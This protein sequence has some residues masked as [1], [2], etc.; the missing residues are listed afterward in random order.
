MT[1]VA[2]RAV[3]VL[4][5]LL[6][7]GAPAG[8]AQST[9]TAAGGLLPDAIANPY[10]LNDTADPEDPTL[11]GGVLTLSTSEDAEIMDYLQ[12]DAQ[13][14]PPDPWVIEIEM[15]HVSGS[16]SVATRA[17]VQ[18]FV[19][20]SPNVGMLFQIGADSLFLMADAVTIGQSATVDT[21]DTFHTY[22]LEVH[23]GG[24]FDVYYDTVLTLQGT[25]YTS[26]SNHGS[27][28]RVGFGP[29]STG[30]HGVS[31]WVSFSHDG[32]AT[33]TTTTFS[34]TTTSST[35]T[36]TT[37]PAPCAP[38]PSGL[39]SWWPGEGDAADIAGTNT[40]SVSGVTF[41]AGRVNQ[42]FEFDGIS[43]T[44]IEVAESSDLKFVGSFSIDAWVQTTG[45]GISG[46]AADLFADVVRKRHRDDGGN[47]DIFL[48]M[49]N[50]VARFGVV[51]DAGSFD[52]PMGI[53]GSTSIN[54]G[55]WHF[56][57][58]VRD[59][60]A[61][62]IALYVDGVLEASLP[63][64][65]GT[66]QEPS[67]VPWNIGNTPGSGSNRFAWDGLIDEVEIF[68]A[69]L[70]LPD[71]Q[72]I[73]NAGSTGKCPLTTTTSTTTT[74]STTSST[75]TT[76]L[77]STTSTTTSTSTTSST[78]LATT[79]TTSTSTSSTTT[80]LVD[81][82][83][84][85]PAKKLQVKQKKSGVQRLQL[86]VKDGVIAAATPCDVDG[87]LVIE[88]VGAGAPVQRYPL[89]ASLWKPIKAKKPEKGCKYRKGPVVATVQIKT[90]KSLKVVANATDLG[91]PLATDPRP[92]RIEV[93][94]GDLR[95]CVEFGGQ[96]KHKP[97]KKLLAKN[98]RAA[99]ICPGG[100]PSGAF[101]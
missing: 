83:V 20:T 85:P 80:T 63:D 45:A 32:L 54:D 57:A 76:T 52:A 5:M 19:T 37:I 62:V 53:Q 46:G 48:G 30:S 94:H 41:G 49:M 97:D 25:T 96:G 101:L 67:V 40:G 64:T 86:L 61:G 21:D 28:Q 44:R 93:R 9:W 66:Y 78:T 100:S 4:S 23:G 12:S 88:A 82:G 68:D 51:D 75:T 50:G 55:N 3:M 90:G 84:F 38:V 95:H 99:T 15:R 58:G 27:V 36:T 42:A 56:L 89:D 10:S 22:R 65:T 60:S 74:S 33:S 11:G 14:A 24:G 6:L 39:V 2:A 18:I 98:A 73:F 81:T 47:L 59:T 79:T 31:E 77:A 29:G 70:T 87:E 91:V 16:S 8:A 26:A 35:S 71:V 34:T 43:T 69:A 13:I 92:V 17:P 1:K 72:A 7:L